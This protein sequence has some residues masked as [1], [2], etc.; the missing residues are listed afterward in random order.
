MPQT[1]QTMSRVNAPAVVLA[2]KPT[3]AKRAPKRRVIA[4]EPAAMAVARQA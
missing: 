4:R 2:Y 3:A 1:P